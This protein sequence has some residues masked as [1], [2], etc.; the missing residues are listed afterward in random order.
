MEQ[1]RK[2]TKATQ[3]LPQWGKDWPEDVIHIVPLIIENQLFYSFLSEWNYL[4]VK[5]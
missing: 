4:L 2:F 1:K 3:G 5:T